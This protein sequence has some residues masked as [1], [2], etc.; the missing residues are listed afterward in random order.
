MAEL[1][2]H[3]SKGRKELMA[4]REETQEQE[5]E[6]EDYTTKINQRFEASLV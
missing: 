3:L 2:A 1:E 4:L 5:L 6:I